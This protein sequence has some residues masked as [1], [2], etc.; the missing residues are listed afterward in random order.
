MEAQNC[1][2]EHIVLGVI[3]SEFKKSSTNWDMVSTE[4]IVMTNNGIFASR[5][6]LFELVKAET[7]QGAQLLT[8]SDHFKALVCLSKGTRQIPVTLC[9]SALISV[10]ARF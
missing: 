7:C 1:R 4:D 10:L 9:K 3:G 2:S 8:N 6:E 5:R